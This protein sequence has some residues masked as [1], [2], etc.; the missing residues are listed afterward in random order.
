M[1]NNAFLQLTAA[2]LPQSS[3]NPAPAF[4]RLVLYKNEVYR[5]PTPTCGIRILS[6]IAWVTTTGEDKILAQGEKVLFPVKKDF[7][8]VS[9]LGNVPLVLET[10]GDDSFYK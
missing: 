1:S 3:S 4:L 6:G 9:A 7:V 5:L 2:N 10:W 8:L